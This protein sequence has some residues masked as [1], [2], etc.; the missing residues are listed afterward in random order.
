MS[1]T[2]YRAVRA[3]C[4]CYGVR[5]AATR[6]RASSARAACSLTSGAP[7]RSRRRSSEMST[8]GSAVK[9]RATSPRI[10]AFGSVV[11]A[12]STLR[13]RPVDGE[14]A[15]PPPAKRVRPVGAVEQRTDGVGPPAGAARP[16]RRRRLKAD[17]VG[18]ARDARVDQRFAAGGAEVASATAA[19]NPRTAR[20][21]APPSAGRGSRPS[22]RSVPRC[23]PPPTAAARR[24]WPAPR[25]GSRRRLASSPRRGGWHRAPRRLLL[26]VDS[27]AA[28]STRSTARASPRR[29]SPT[30]AGQEACRRRRRPGRSRRAGCARR[31]LRRC[32]ASAVTASISMPRG[33]ACPSASSSARARRPATAGSRCVTPGA[34]RRRRRA[35]CR[36]CRGR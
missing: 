20:P 8:F 11:P 2:V 19:L 7:S 12:V 16:S 36:G 27:R 14:Q 26:P 31:T 10:A 6:D 18:G 13:R 22:S 21:P 5:R 23:R 25:A 15:A 24:G 32:S 3:S 28:R 29:A 17:V 1:A 9:I 4:C 33:P 35:P 30:T 34:T